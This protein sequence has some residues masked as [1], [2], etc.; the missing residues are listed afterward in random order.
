MTRSER[1]NLDCCSSGNRRRLLD[2][3]AVA[4]LIIAISSPADSI[5]RAQQPS[6]PAPTPNPAAPPTPDP[7]TAG[8]FQITSAMPGTAPQST[9]QITSAP[10]AAAPQ[11]LPILTRHEAVRLALIQASTFQQAKL[12]EMI[13][14]EDVRQA[15]AA[16]LPQVNIPSE[17]IYTSPTHAIVQQPG[18]PPTPSVIANNAVTE[19]LAVIGFSGELDMFGRLR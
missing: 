17:F 2:R 9:S 7:S 4:L 18:T 12:N 1:K 16:L 14:A 15:R 19:Y 3:L 5:T 10:Q 6:P 8:P 11:P 13:A